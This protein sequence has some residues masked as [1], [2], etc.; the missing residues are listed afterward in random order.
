VGPAIELAYPNAVAIERHLATYP[1]NTW[2]PST[3]AGSPLTKE[4]WDQYMS[5]RDESRNCR[6]IME[7]LRDRVADM[8]ARYGGFPQYFTAFDGGVLWQAA[9]GLQEFSEYMMA[10]LP[11]HAQDHAVRIGRS[12]GASTAFLTPIYPAVFVKRGTWEDYYSPI[13]EG[14]PP[15]CTDTNKAYTVGGYHTLL[16]YPHGRGYINTHSLSDPGVRRRLRGPY[17]QYRADLFDGVMD[18]LRLS[19]FPYIFARIA[20]VKMNA[21]LNNAPE[22]I[23]IP[24]W[25]FSYDVASGK[26]RGGANTVVRVTPN[27]RRARTCELRDVEFGADGDDRDPTRYHALDPVD[28]IASDR[29]VDQPHDV[30]RDLSGTHLADWVWWSDR[31][32]KTYDPA[33]MGADKS[34]PH[35]GEDP[36][37]TD[38]EEPRPFWYYHRYEKWSFGGVLMDTDTYD[39]SDNERLMGDKSGYYPLLLDTTQAGIQHRY[40]LGVWEYV[41]FGLDGGHAKLW[42]RVFGNPN[43]AGKN[44][45]YAQVRVHN[46]TSWDL[47]TQN[48]QATLVP[49]AHLMNVNADAFAADIAR[50]REWR[51]NLSED[52]VRPVA[53]LYNRLPNNPSVI[54]EINN[55]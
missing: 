46:P 23:S 24:R 34:C 7:E 9:H 5:A 50:Y 52:D 44:T 17:R 11:S 18:E 42:S 30:W 3:H 10:L 32:V 12:N 49:A 47:F 6:I 36:P 14:L 41:A 21:I 37:V 16:G 8:D 29:D 28:P 45:A 4:M 43:P 15:D 38:G 26:H 25:E 2:N 31:R 19:G 40:E 27:T 53:T 48:W 55:H 33:D 35:D 13:T 1:P 39:T 54:D 51:D 22:P 20:S